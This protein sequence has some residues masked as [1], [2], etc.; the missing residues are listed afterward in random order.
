MNKKLKFK[1][2]LRLYFRLP[3]W[4][5]ILLACTDAVIYTI[6]VASG[7]ILSGFTLVYLLCFLFLEHF[8]RSIIMNELVSFAT[9]YGQIQKRLLRDLELPNAL[10]DESGRVIWANR[11]FQQIV[12]KERSENKLISGYFPEISKDKLPIGEEDATEVE[13]QQDDKD[14][15]A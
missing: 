1:G 14:F 12:G 4:F 5:G 9:Q 2:K 8:N 15:H 11:A 10:L 13:F 6:D 7:I 3:V